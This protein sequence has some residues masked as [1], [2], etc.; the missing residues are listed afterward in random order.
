M[1]QHS[2]SSTAVTY[3]KEPL[4]VHVD[5]PAAFE[6]EELGPT[7]LLMLIQYDSPDPDVV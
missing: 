6:A 1:G 3:S 7:S 4:E 2:R 5:G